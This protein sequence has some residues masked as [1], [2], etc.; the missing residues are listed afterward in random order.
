MDVQ[1]SF[2]L[3]TCGDICRYI[4]LN[5]P[6]A[7]ELFGAGFLSDEPTYDA[8]PDDQALKEL[9][10]IGSI[11]AS[12]CTLETLRF[13]TR[14]L[15]KP[16]TYSHKDIYFDWCSGQWLDKPMPDEPWDVAVAHIS[17]LVVSKDIDS[18]IELKN[19][20]EEAIN[21]LIAKK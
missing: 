12:G 7:E 8:Y 4:G 1:Q 18:L 2:P 9:M 20:A 14:S 10:F 13:V 15:P 5:W 21:E 6:M 16:Y 17:E 11:I 3:E 19:H